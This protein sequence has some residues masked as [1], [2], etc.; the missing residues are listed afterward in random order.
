MNDGEAP[1]SRAPWLVAGVIV[2][3]GGAGLFAARGDEAEP[4]ASDVARLRDVSANPSHLLELVGATGSQMVPCL[5]IDS[6]EGEVHWM[7]E[8]ADIIKYLQHHFSGT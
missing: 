8:S 6:S 2:L 1:G 5:R 3:A 4:E 7:H